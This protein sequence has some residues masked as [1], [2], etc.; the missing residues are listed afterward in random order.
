M[1]QCG[2]RELLRPMNWTPCLSLSYLTVSS[3]SLPLPFHPSLFVSSSS[4]LH[5]STPLFVSSSSFYPCRHLIFR[6]FYS[7]SSFCHSLSTPHP[8][9]F[10]S[11]PFFFCLLP[12]L[13][14][15]LPYSDPPSLPSFLSSFPLSP[16]LQLPGESVQF[17]GTFI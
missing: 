1:D 12:T 2:F 9:F 8:F 16:F 5:S 15:I 17:H 4:L 6:S 11:F 14:L 13:F 7:F 10:S 3:S